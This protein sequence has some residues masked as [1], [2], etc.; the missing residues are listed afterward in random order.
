M[1]L[2][3]GAMLTARCP[4]DVAA[5]PGETIAFSADQALVYRFDRDGRALRQG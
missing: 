3:D 2:D 4:E 1:R 5:A